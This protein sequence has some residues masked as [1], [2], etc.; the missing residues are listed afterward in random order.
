MKVEV[1]KKVIIRASLKSVG[2]ALNMSE[3]DVEKYKDF[4]KL[5]EDEGD[6]ELGTVQE[7]NESSKSKPTKKK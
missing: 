2:D 5:I 6:K 3:R 4:V 1:V 7:S